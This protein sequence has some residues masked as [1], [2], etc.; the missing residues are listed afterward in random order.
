MTTINIPPDHRAALLVD[1]DDRSHE[2]FETVMV[3]KGYATRLF[4]DQHKAI[5]WL[6]L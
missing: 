3:N 5:T 4:H 2:F 1:P 6:V